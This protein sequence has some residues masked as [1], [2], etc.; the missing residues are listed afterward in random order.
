MLKAC[1]QDARNLRQVSPVDER[2]H[3][4]RACIVCGARH[5]E[6]TVDPIVVAV[7]LAQVR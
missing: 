7:D 6:L 1:C 2:A 5:Y 3:V 4:V